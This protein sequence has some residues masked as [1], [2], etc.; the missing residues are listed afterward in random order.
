ME[1]EV[2]PR[3]A[4]AAEGLQTSSVALMSAERFTLPE[5]T[6]RAGFGMPF[7]A[8]ADKLGVSTTAL[9]RAC[10]TAGIHRC[11]WDAGAGR[12]SRGACIQLLANHTAMLPPIVTAQ[13]A[14]P[15]RACRLLFGGGPQAAV[16]L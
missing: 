1:A 11:E 10:T 6:I 15:L 3:S 12:G 16:A 14:L 4:T 13:V 9:K 5:H 7:T 2:E 8:F